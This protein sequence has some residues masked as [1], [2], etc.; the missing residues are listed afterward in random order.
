[1]GTIVVDQ[2]A[3]SARFLE[4]QSAVLKILGSSPGAAEPQ[5][6]V[7][8]ISRKG[9]YTVA[10]IIAFL[11]AVPGMLALIKFL[12]PVII[13]VIHAARAAQ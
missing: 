13:G 4:N 6:G 5:A 2:K 11:A 9:A 7:A 1:M 12:A 3:D 8:A 10:G